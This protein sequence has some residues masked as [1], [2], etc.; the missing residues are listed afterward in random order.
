MEK[1]AF[2]SLAKTERNSQNKDLEGTLVLLEDE[3]KTND[4]KLQNYASES[5]RLEERIK[6]LASK[7]NLLDDLNKESDSLKARIKGTQKENKDL[8][9]NA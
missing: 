1:K 2:A 7:P 5:A 8:K 3:K 6:Y 4:T 9:R